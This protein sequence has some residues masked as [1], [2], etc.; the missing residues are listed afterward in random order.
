[1]KNQ[2]ERE[3]ECNEVIESNNKKNSKITNYKVSKEK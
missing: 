3:E 2:N 1:M